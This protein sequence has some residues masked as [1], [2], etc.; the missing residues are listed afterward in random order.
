MSHVYH[1]FGTNVITQLTET[2]TIH[3]ET[4]IFWTVPETM[5]IQ[6]IDVIVKMCQLLSVSFAKGLITNGVFAFVL[7]IS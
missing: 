5:A 2:F 3:H 7:Y 6:L 1:G 4:D